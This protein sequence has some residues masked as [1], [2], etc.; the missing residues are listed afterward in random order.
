VGVPAFGCW[1]DAMP[2][3]SQRR[4]SEKKFE[5]PEKKVDLVKKIPGASKKNFFA[6]F[7]LFQNAE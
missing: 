7:F 4:P 1:L 3:E 6:N 5:K 2:R